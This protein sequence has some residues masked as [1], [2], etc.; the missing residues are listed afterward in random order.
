MTL[1]QKALGSVVGLPVLKVGDKVKLVQC[2]VYGRVWDPNETAEVIFV[3]G[4]YIQVYTNHTI[5]L[6]AVTSGFATAPRF[7][8][9]E[10]GS[11]YV[12]TIARI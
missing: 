6:D 9:N 4:D 11:R 1:L 5:R 7:K 8:A 3:Q 10:R 2:T 12:Y